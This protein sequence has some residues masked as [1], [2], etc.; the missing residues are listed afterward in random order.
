MLIVQFEVE[1]CE[2]ELASIKNTGI[3]QFRVIHFFDDFRWN[4]LRWIAVVC[5]KHVEHFLVHDPVMQHLRWRFYEIPR[6]MRSGE[7]AVPPARDTRV[8]SATDV[9]A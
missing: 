6:H 5:R 4:F 8:K 3:R 7:T 2:G 9:V 1:R